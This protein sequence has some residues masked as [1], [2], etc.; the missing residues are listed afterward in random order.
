MPRPLPEAGCYKGGWTVPTNVTLPDGG[1]VN[2]T[3]PIIIIGSF[4]QDDTNTITIT[5]SGAI[6]GTYINVTGTHA[7]AR[8]TM[9]P[10]C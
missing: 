3:S 6:P 1:R 9:P 10:Q 8:T 5:V 2:L 7:L 4:T